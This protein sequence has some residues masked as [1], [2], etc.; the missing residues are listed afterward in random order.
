MLLAAS[1]TAIAAWGVFVSRLYDVARE[2]FGT[3]DIFEADITA[4]CRIIYAVDVISG[5][6]TAYRSLKLTGGLYSTVKRENYFEVL[7]A[8]FKELSAL[9][10]VKIDAIISF[11]TF[12]RGA[13][14]TSLSFNNWVNKDMEICE[15]SRK[16]DVVQVAYLLFL[17]LESAQTACIALMEKTDGLKVSAELANRHATDAIPI[18]LTGLVLYKYLHLRMI[19]KM[20]IQLLWFLDKSISI[21]EREDERRLR[22]ELRLQNEKLREHPAFHCC[23][24]RWGAMYEGS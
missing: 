9:G 22:I 17:S 1:G 11:Y 16:T 14:D 18:S 21:D 8:S 10:P 7:E 4:I 13:R 15:S 6:V 19:E 24:E 12:L 23:Q 20:K 5:Y 3:V 2:R